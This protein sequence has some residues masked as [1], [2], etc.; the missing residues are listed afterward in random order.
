M[1]N[2]KKKNKHPALEENSDF[3]KFGDLPKVKYKMY[4]QSSQNGNPGFQVSSSVI[5]FATD[6]IWRHRL[7]LEVTIAGD[8][9][10]ANFSLYWLFFV[11]TL[12]SLTRTDICG[13][14]CHVIIPLHT[15]QRFLRLV[16]VKAF[17]SLTQMSSSFPNTYN[18]LLNPISMRNTKAIMIHVSNAK[19]TGLGNAYALF[20]L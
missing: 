6:L 17:Q 19:L 7:I 4:Q 13:F 2:C 9:R 3:R 14:L 1:P 11:F 5:H 12:T 15:S 8:K 18:L 10:L 16:F 20:C